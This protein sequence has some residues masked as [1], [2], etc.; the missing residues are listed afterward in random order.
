[1]KVRH[2]AI[3]IPISVLLMSACKNPFSDLF[4]SSTSPSPNNPNT[5]TFNGNLAPNTSLVFTFVVANTGNVAV[6]LTAVSPATTGTLALGV[7]PAATDGSCTI[8]SSTSAATAGTNPQLSATENAGN[9]CVKVTDAGALTTT[10]AVT[11]TVTHP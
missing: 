7:G 1:M 10:S 5:E 3:L 4:G 6:T 8:A 2:L 9:Y 11:V